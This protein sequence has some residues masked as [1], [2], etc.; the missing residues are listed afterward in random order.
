M[1]LFSIW[2]RLHQIRNLLIQQIIE[3]I[4]FLLFESNR[5]FVSICY[6]FKFIFHHFNLICVSFWRTTFLCHF[7]SWIW[8]KLATSRL[9]QLWFRSFSDLLEFYRFCHLFKLRFIRQ[10]V[11]DAV[12]RIWLWTFILFFIIILQFP[13]LF[14]FRILQCNFNLIV[15]CIIMF[16]LILRFNYSFWFILYFRT[17]LSSIIWFLVNMFGILYIIALYPQQ[18]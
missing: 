16:F 13:I 4:W 7:R 15:T 14:F 6:C 3:L 9:L 18:R 5:L 1:S 10:T 17:Y 2:L 11:F 8:G 12:Q